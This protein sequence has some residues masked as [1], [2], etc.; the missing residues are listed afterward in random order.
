MIPLLLLVGAAPLAEAAELSLS[1]EAALQQALQRNPTLL[2]AGLDVESAEGAALSS[3]ATFDPFLEANTGISGSRSESVGQFGRA[4]TDFNATTWGSNLTQFTATGTTLSLGLSSTRSQFTY[5]LLD[6]PGFDPVSDVQFDSRLSLGFT[7]SLLEGHR[8]ASN[9]RAVRD[10]D[11]ARDMAE[12]TA[13]ETRQQTL[14]DVATAYWNLWYQEQLVA[15]A[16]QSLAVAREEQRIVAARVDAGDVAPVEASRVAAAAVQAQQLLIDSR[17]LA[18]A[19][20]DTLLLLLGELPGQDVVLESRPEAPVAVSLDPDALVNEALANNA[21]LQVM[22][23]TEENARA[24]LADSRHRRLP[25]LDAVGSYG[26]TGY[27]DTQ[28][29]AFQEMLEGAL[30]EWSVGANLSVP[31]GN[32][33]D[34]GTVLSNQAAAA[35]AR[36]N[37]EALERTIAQ[38]VRAQVR[39]IEGARAQ[40]DL[41]QANLELAEQTLA[42]DRALLDAGRTIQRDVLESIKNVDDARAAL[43]KARADH[44]L[45][46]VEL[47]RLRGAL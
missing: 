16:E 30:P 38:Q 18:A 46:V 8:W 13:L 42:A 34:R 9:V 27:E 25:Q 22:R 29:G 19:A 43:E 12:V 4:R 3:R 36:T 26:L 10:A 14:A 1:Y 44:A 32:R 41:A 37:R 2:S 7:Q 21:S 35:Q 20:S 45:A 40:V 23:L 5:E 6:V 11:R 17:N 33:A 31:L 39:V 24:A 47:Q 28:S 15:I